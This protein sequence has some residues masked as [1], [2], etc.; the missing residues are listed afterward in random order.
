MCVVKAMCNYPAAT[1]AG[2][3]AGRLGGELNNLA[4]NGWSS[5]GKGL[6]CTRQ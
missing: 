1:L 5:A 6:K 2:C 3:L 4:G